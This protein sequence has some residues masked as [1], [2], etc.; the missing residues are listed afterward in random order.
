MITLSDRLYYPWSNKELKKWYPRCNFVIFLYS[1]PLPN[2][3]VPSFYTFEPILQI[4]NWNIFRHFISAELTIPELQISNFFFSTIRVKFSKIFRLPWTMSFP[5]MSWYQILWRFT[6]KK[7]CHCVTDYLKMW[8]SFPRVTCSLKKWTARLWRE[9]ES[10]TML[11]RLN[12]KFAKNVT[13]LAMK[14]LS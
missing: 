6:L 5:R 13:G 3:T 11:S 2:A 8:H 1:A 14:K 4:S 9:A 10:V 12:R 7:S